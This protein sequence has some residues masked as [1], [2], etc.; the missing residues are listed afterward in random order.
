MH[1][2]WG[3]PLSSV[4]QDVLRRRFTSLRLITFLI[5]EMLP[6]TCVR[7]LRLY[8]LI[9][10]V[11]TDGYNSLIL[12]VDYNI[13][14]G[15]TIDCKTWRTYIILERVVILVSC[16]FQS[17]HVIV[18]NRRGKCRCSRFFSEE[19]AVILRIGITQIIIT[20][21]NTYCSRYRS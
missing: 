1:L 6:P 18:S 17:K 8:G 14:L 10:P 13:L 20:Q 3:H 11:T 9:S 21:L 7:G 2:Y 4:I 15:S 12:F 16:N 5:A 19:L